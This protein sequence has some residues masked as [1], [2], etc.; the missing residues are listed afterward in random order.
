LQDKRPHDGAV[1]V[2]GPGSVFKTEGGQ[3]TVITAW[4]LALGTVLVFG[5]AINGE[6]LFDDQAILDMERK[7]KVGAYKLFRVYGFDWLNSPLDF[8]FFW[9]GI[10]Q[11][12]SIT[13]FVYY[14]TWR[15]F[16]YK[17]WAWHGVS[18]AMHAAATFG[19]YLVFL[20]LWGHPGAL[21]AAGVFG[22]HPHQAAAV[23]YVSGRAGLQATM[24]TIFGLVLF[25]WG[26][27]WITG[28][29]LCSL[30][31]WKSKQ[32]G[33]LYAAFYPIYAA[34]LTIMPAI[35]H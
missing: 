14:W 18:L 23:C 26:G 28:A 8:R 24:L 2:G 1:C 12:R 10:R 29:A 19:A 11:D 16:G 13:H 30:L 34:L 4:L 9:H 35:T 31:A 25:S 33:I 6:F 15:V 7:F 5:R 17:R 20:P 32:D 22:Y 3:E 27:L 21:V